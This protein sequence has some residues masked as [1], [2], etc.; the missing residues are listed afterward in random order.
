MLIVYEYM[1]H[2]KGYIA[3]SC[4]WGGHLQDHHILCDRSKLIM[5]PRMSPSAY[6]F[7]SHTIPLANFGSII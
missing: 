6:P 1:R 4:Y 7:F 5:A 2:A 3:L